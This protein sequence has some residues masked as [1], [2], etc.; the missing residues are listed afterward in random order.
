MTG[1][2]AVVT[3][4]TPFKV[5]A[6]RL[7]EHR[8]AALPVVD[9]RDRAIGIVSEADLLVKEEHLEH[10]RS[11]RRDPDRAKAAGTTAGEIMSTPVV[12]VG[13][14]TT[15]GDAARL[16]HLHGFRSMPVVDLDGRVVGIVARRDLLKAFLRPDADIHDEIVEEIVRDAMWLEPDTVR[17]TVDQGVVVLDGQLERASLVPVLVRLAEG[18]DG[19]VRVESHLSFDFDDI[20]IRPVAAAPWGVVPYGTR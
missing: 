16:M 11:R 15:L 19:V 18:V 17:V 3:A 13:P 14:E 20:G 5:V 4:D 10:D 2:V 1:T 6:R 12:T 9:A 7:A 8:V